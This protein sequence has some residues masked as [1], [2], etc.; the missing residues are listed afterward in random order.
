MKYIPR[1]PCLHCGNP[2]KK[3]STTTCSKRCSNFIKWK[4]KRGNIRDYLINK[5]INY[6]SKD[7]STG[8]WNWNKGKSDR[9]YAEISINARKERANRISYQVFI[10]EVP[11]HLFVCHTCDNPG[12]VNPDHLYLGTHQD[13]VDD[14]LD[15]DRQPRGEEIKLAKLTEKDILKIRALWKEGFM[16]Q[17]SIAREFGVCQTTISRVILRQTWTHV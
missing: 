1:K 8:C 12:C 6:S 15:R 5:I 16:S 14:K 3:T 11:P 10:D 7:H 13:N 2:V 17:E 4:R 9:G